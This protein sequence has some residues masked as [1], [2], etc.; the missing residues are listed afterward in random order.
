MSQ[1]QMIL[2]M[3]AVAAVALAWRV[4]R[5]WLW[6]ALGALDFIATTAYARGG[7]EYPSFF[8]VIVDGLVCAC[9]FFIATRRWEMQ[10]G[11]LFMAMMLVNL[12]YFLAEHIAKV[13]MSHAIYITVLEV[14]N[15]LV[16]CLIGGIGT[17]ERGWAGGYRAWNHRVNPLH[18]LGSHLHA[19]RTDRPFHRRRKGNSS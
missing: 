16:L 10:I 2:A 17:M 6:V 18:L 8:S 12:V 15:A 3:A 19:E 9:I 5:A 7:W 1:Y 13:E 4:P 11:R 14:L